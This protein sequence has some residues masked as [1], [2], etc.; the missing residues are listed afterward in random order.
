MVIIKMMPLV[1]VDKYNDDYKTAKSKDFYFLFYFS[2]EQSGHHRTF[3]A[4]S[5]IIAATVV[6]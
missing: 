4:L 3:P 5:V 1:H 2:K 6:M